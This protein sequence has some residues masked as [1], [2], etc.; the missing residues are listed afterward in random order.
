ML[1]K[2]KQWIFTKRNAFHDK[3][4]AVVILAIALFVVAILIPPALQQ[5]YTANTSGW[6]SAVITVFQVLLP[7]LAIIAVAL[8]FFRE[9][10]T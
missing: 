6:N 7:V 2:I 10:K 5:V 4:G 9:V 1:E 8:Y 3:I